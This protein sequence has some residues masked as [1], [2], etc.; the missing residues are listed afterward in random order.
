[1]PARSPGDSIRFGIGSPNRRIQIWYGILLTISV[2]FIARLFY[3][4]VIKHDYYSQQALNDQLKEYS[5]APERGI[6]EAHEA[7]GVVPIVLN[8]Q[9]YTLYADPLLVKDATSASF[10]LANITKGDPSQYVKLM[11]TS[12]SRYE[13]LAKRLSEKQKNQ[14]LSLKLPGIGAQ[15][16]DYRVYPQGQLAAQLLGFVNNDGVGTYGV[17]QALNKQLSGTPGLLKA[18]TDASGVPLAANKDN[19]QISPKAGDNVVLTINLAMQKQLENILKQGLEKAK[20]ASGSA[21]IIDPTSGAI[22]AMANL[23]SY[24][25]ATFYNV[26]DPRVFNNAAV[27]EPLEVGSIMKT[28]TTSAALDLGVI[29]PDTSYYDPSHWLLDGH[30]ITNIEE[31]GG[32]G[33]HNIAE[34]LNLSINTGATWMLMQMGGQTGTVTRQARDRWHDY[35]VNHFQLGKPTGIEQGYEAPGY[36]PSPDQG[37]ALQL[38]YANTAFGQALTITPLQMVAALSS[39]LNGGTYY[40]PRLVDSI[41]DSSGRVTVKKPQIVRRNVVNPSVGQALQ[42]LMEYVV[43]GHLDAGFRD[44]LFP[45]NYS[46]GGKTG[47]AQIANPAGGYFANKYNG[48]YIGFVGGD[49]PQYVIMVR[50]NQ[51]GIAGYAGAQAAQPIFA[52]LAHMLINDFNVI[53]K[54]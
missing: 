13:V 17:E 4:Q 48:T 11:K 28:L 6:I 33:T 9:L 14:A 5:I 37:Y 54:K 47:T 36:I 25:P 16:Q 12:G 34:I 18:I 30:E 39:V 46:V 51:P 7:G 1:M 43:K 49:Q 29:K 21:L 52:D 40:R 44:L 2:I 23:P 15:A 22:K 10:K 20:S 8:Q 24:D 41:I 19:V 26:T 53:P 38:T 50:V 45:G 27:S 35:M 42:S 3:L 32:A 31:D